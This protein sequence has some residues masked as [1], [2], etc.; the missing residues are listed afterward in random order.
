MLI[1]QHDMAI[2]EKNGSKGTTLWEVI[3]H[4]TG[5]QYAHL[6]TQSV[7][8]LIG[9]GVLISYILVFLLMTTATFSHII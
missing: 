6:T 5:T 4:L 1:D 3:Q 8:E 9:L 7:L 2:R